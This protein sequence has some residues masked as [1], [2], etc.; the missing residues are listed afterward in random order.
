[1]C[2]DVY[3]LSQTSNTQMHKF[4]MMMRIMMKD[5]KNKKIIYTLR[6][7]LFQI[8]CTFSKQILLEWD[9]KFYVFFIK[10]AILYMLTHFLGKLGRLGSLCPHWICL[11]LLL[12]ITSARSLLHLFLWIFQTKVLFWIVLWYLCL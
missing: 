4:I 1:M 12:F 10:V 2:C 7:H 6:N 11:L 8:L 9:L 3:V 5:S